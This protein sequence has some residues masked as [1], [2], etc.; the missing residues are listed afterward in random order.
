M[1]LFSWS[2]DLPHLRGKKKNSPPSKR[3]FS[4]HLSFVGILS[5]VKNKIPG[6]VF[7]NRTVPRKDP[8]NNPS[9]TPCCGK[10][11]CISRHGAGRTQLA[12]GMLHGVVVWMGYQAIFVHLVNRG[13]SLLLLFSLV[14][15]PEVL[16]LPRE[17]GNLP[18]GWQYYLYP[19]MPL[20]LRGGFS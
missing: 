18:T 6:Q 14:Q 10:A 3:G 15:I 1:P 17:S 12:L 9:L 7:G 2:L 8:C 16:V 4:P 20:Q 13:E 11:M 5:K 19:E